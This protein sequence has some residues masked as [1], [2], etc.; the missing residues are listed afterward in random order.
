MFG[1]VGVIAGN[2]FIFALLAAAA[3]IAIELIW[4]RLPGKEKNKSTK[5]I[6]LITG[7]SSGLGA[8]YARLVAT[9]AKETDEI[10]LVARRLDRLQ[11]LADSFSVKV[12]CLALDLTSKEDLEKLAERLMEQNIRIGLLINCAGF[13]KIGD[14]A[15]VSTMNKKAMISLNCT[16]AV[17]LTDMCIPFMG[18]GDRIINVCSTAAF[19]PFQKLGIYAASKAF[20]LRYTRTLRLELLPKRIMVSAVCP[21]WINDTE[22]ISV[23]DTGDKAIK[24]FPFA[25][26]VSTVS[27]VSYTCAMWGLPVITPGIICTIH[28]FFSKLLPDTA[29]QY[30]WEGI[31]RI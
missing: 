13:G 7:A 6:A 5:R 28:R 18:K 22:F 23:A 29:L 1:I 19:Q 9:K 15:T 27:R 21:Y 26:K 31:R 12:R 14:Y 25:S 16:A 4:Y 2:I 30:I 8:E 3:V 17:T 11:H 10:W 20:L 24:S